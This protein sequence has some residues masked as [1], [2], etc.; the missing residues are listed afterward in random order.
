MPRGDVEKGDRMIIFVDPPGRQ[1]PGDDLAEDAIGVD[2]LS[3]RR[4]ERRHVIMFSS[5]L[6]AA[7]RPSWAAISR[8]A[9]GKNAELAPPT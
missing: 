1:F 5:S 3:R 9:R 4:L 8:S 7:K 6:P 2:A